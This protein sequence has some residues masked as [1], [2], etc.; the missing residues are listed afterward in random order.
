MLN[1]KIGDWFY[2]YPELA[3][4]NNS[5]VITKSTPKEAYEQV[6]KSAKQFGEPGIAFL[7]SKEF[8]YNPCMEVGMFPTLEIEVEEDQYG[9][10]TCNLTEINGKKADTFQNFLKAARVAAILGTFQAAYTDFP[11]LGKIT[12]EIIR[13]DAL[14]GVGITGMSEHPSILFSPLYQKEVAK[15]V[16][17]VNAEVAAIL[18]INTAARTTVVKPSGNSSQMLGTS[19]GVHP[20]HAHRYIR[21]VQVNKDEFA[22]QIYKKINPDAV[23][24]SAWNPDKDY[25]IS[26][27]VEIREN[28]LVKN[29][30]SAEQ[31]MGL[32]AM[33]QQAWIEEGTNWDHPSTKRNPDLRHNVS[34]TITVRDHEWEDVEKY[35]WD[36]KEKFCGISMLG[37]NGDID[38]PQAPYTEVFTEAKLAEMYGAAA[39]LG[40]GL[41]VDGIHAFG[42]LW[43]ARDATT[44]KGG[45]LE[46]TADDIAK[47]IGQNVDGDLNFKYLLNGVVLTD[48]NAI[49]AHMR[50]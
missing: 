36:N 13:R 10:S 42:D 44:G 31:F 33:T 15:E 40:S 17:K 23:Q 39:I 49:I 30:Q 1:C 50:D 14:I 28:A 29:N 35:L 38:Y 46:I 19:S 20:F 43:S 22:G 4:A 5:I 7:K 3:R 25:V 8:T 21:N 11:Y 18:G 37:G 12:E 32:V 16:K 41:I 26:F 6:F 45:K 24:S 9:W 2:R 27:P 48:V 47:K 34:N